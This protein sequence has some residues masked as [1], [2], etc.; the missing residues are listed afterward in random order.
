MLYPSIAERLQT[1]HLAIENIIQP[2]SNERLQ[3]RPQPG[4]WNI[5]DNMAHLGSYQPVFIGRMQQILDNDTP[6]FSRYKADEDTEF[7]RWQKMDVVTLIQQMAEDRKNIHAFLLSLSTEQLNRTGK[8][9]KY[10]TLS[11]VQWTEFFLLHEA[12]HIFTIF[13]LANDVDLK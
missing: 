3:L 13:Q 12:H 2:L 8:H 10:G 7:M 6:A 4:K 9:A 11:I 1:Q 5:H